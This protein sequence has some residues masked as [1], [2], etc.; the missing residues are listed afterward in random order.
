M[1]RTLPRQTDAPTVPDSIIAPMDPR[2]ITA[3]GFA[4]A[5]NQGIFVRVVAPKTGIIRD[6]SIFI[7]TSAGNIDVAIYDSAATTINR[8]YSTGAIA[9]P[10]TTNWAIV[11][12]P[13]ILV[14]RGQVLY[15]GVS[16]SSATTGI[17]RATALTSTQASV[18]PTGFWPASG[19]T[20]AKVVMY[21]AALHP[22]PA[23]Y[24]YANG[25]VTN[26]VPALM[27]RVE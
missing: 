20:P 25:A 5:V 27:A 13:Q 21:D 11:G 16:C 1:P 17:G 26:S 7:T 19:A 6:L 9:C 14:T 2:L 10:A 24:T 4:L 3:A 22:F 8:L 18:L 23:T 15:L 12:D